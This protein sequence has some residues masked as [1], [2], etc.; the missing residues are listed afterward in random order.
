MHKKAV[1]MKNGRLYLIVIINTND[2]LQK[3][4]LHV[5]G[6]EDSYS[7]KKNKWRYGVTHKETPRMCQLMVFKL[8]SIVEIDRLTNV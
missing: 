7:N 4:P 2:Y 8:V 5:K 1:G 6:K 3:F